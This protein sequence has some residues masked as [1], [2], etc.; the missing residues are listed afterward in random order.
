MTKVCLINPPRL[1][2]KGDAIFIY[3]PVGIAHLASY[4]KSMDI[5]VKVIDMIV[6]GRT[7]LIQVED[8]YRNGMKDEDLIIKLKEFQPDFVGIS[9]MFTAQSDNLHHIA[10]VIKN[11]INTKVVAGGVHVS[12]C[13]EKVLEDKNIDY[14]IVGEGEDSFLNII[15]F[16]ENSKEKIYKSKFNIKLSPIPDYSLFNMEKYLENTSPWTYLE[17]R[18]M[19][20]VTSRGCPYNC[21]FCSIHNSMDRNWRGK[22]AS[23]VLEEIRIL[24]DKYNVEHLF[25]EDDNI[26]FDE[27]RAIEIFDGMTGMGLTWE[28]PNGI[29][30]DTLIPKLLDSIKASGCKKLV[31]SIESGC[32]EFLNNVVN[33]KLDL[34]KVKEVAKLMYERDIDIA[35]FYI[36]GIPGETKETL[37]ETVNFAKYLAKNYGVRPYFMFA[38]PLPNTDMW[39]NAEKNGY[40]KKNIIPTDYIKGVQLLKFP[41]ISMDEMLKIQRLAYDDIKALLLLHPKSLLRSDTLLRIKRKIFPSRRFVKQEY[42]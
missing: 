32:Q 40:L 7:T 20:I 26:T 1:L 11:N 18:C 13:A 23:V 31:I 33:K 16:G 5:E 22:D 15:Q 34:E 10:G 19:S 3:F 8:L 9:S 29:R 28:T 14:A 12:S 27:K 4:L 42:V 17:K 24:R 35:S 25:I 41:S 38:N 2:N 36:F 37:S 21:T 39:R 6:E 30:V